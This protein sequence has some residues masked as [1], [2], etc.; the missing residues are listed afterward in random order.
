[1]ISNHCEN[2]HIILNMKS[3]IKVKHQNVLLNIYFMS[4]PT[5]SWNLLIFYRFLNVILLLYSL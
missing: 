3:N 2:I 4:D 5:S 1:M